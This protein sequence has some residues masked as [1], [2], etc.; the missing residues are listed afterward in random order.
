MNTRRKPA[1]RLCTIVMKTTSELNDQ[2]GIHGVVDFID[3]SPA[4]PAI[5]IQNAHAKALIALHGG[6]VMEYQPHGHDPVLW[7]SKS[8]LL[9]EGKPIRGGIPVCWPWFANHATDSSL[10]PHGFVRT[11]FWS[12][13]AVSQS[14][15]GTTI[16]K[17]STAHDEP[18]FEVW[19]HQFR[20]ELTVEVGAS[21]SVG[22]RMENAD[23]TP[24]ECAAALHTYLTVGEISKIQVQGLDGVSYTDKLQNL[25]VL[26]Q[27][28]PIRFDAECDRIYQ[29]TTSDVTVCDA[30]LDREIC[31]SKT[32]SQ[33]TVVWNPWIAKAKALSDFDDEGY[34]T[35]V[36]IETACALTDVIHVEPNSAHEMTTT[37]SVRRGTANK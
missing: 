18:S 8:T 23:S 9:E 6:H 26:K 5:Q 20:L 35:M 29:P 30:A 34:L 19:P 17:L 25:A 32:G 21:L 2:F 33:S 22:M 37:V 24:W 15:T 14:A 4:Y 13:D 3:L 1:S 12:L 10:P 27:S 7:M 16:V 31:V 11:K 36:C 28:G